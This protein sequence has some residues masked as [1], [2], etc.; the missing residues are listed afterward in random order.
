MGIIFFAFIALVILEIIIRLNNEESKSLINKRVIFMLVF[1]FVILPTLI[2][3]GQETGFIKKNSDNARLEKSSEHIKIEK[4]IV[5]ENKEIKNSIYKKLNKNN[6]EKITQNE[7]NKIKEITE[8]RTHDLSELAF[9]KNL[10]KLS[11]EWSDDD[12][13]L[14]I[15]NLNKLK[16]LKI[17]N[18]PNID[19]IDYLRNLNKLEYLSISNDNLTNIDV[20]E[21]LSNLKEL[22]LSGENIR[23]LSPIDKMINLE[24]LYIN[25][26]KITDNY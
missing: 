2:L 18:C 13:L 11:I 5:I 22:H 26:E 6:T 8:L 19:N 14:A 20:L 9:L 10:E 7:L 23:D 1:V 16:Y 4:G 21:Y 25:G 3:I 15:Q 12:S 24:I 17:E